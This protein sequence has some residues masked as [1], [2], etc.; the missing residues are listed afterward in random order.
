MRFISSTL[1]F[2]AIAGLA[3][4]TKLLI[5]SDST[6][7]NY[8]LDGA[9]QGYCNSQSLRDILG[10]RRETTLTKIQ[11]GLLPQQ[12]HYPGSKQPR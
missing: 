9:L 2:A 1:T 11:M 10:C 5:C 6:T 8:A 7:A 3:S 4:A 12:L